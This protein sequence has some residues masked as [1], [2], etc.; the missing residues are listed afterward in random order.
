MMGTKGTEGIRATLAMATAEMDIPV[1][2]R[3]TIEMDAPAAV[4]TLIEVMMVQ[5]A[6]IPAGTRTAD[7]AGTEVDNNWIVYTY[8]QSFLNCSNSSWVY[9][10]PYRTCL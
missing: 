10:P 8:I 1:V 7:G 5:G 9:P 4:G 6:K 3:T 2:T